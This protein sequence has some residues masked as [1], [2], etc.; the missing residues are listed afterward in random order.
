MPTQ[1]GAPPPGQK[2][3]KSKSGPPDAQ[4]NS[5]TRGPASRPISKAVSSRTLSE[6][7]AGC[8][9][10]ICEQ[11]LNQEKRSSR[12]PDD[13]LTLMMR[14][15]LLE[16]GYDLIGLIGKGGMGTVYKAQYVGTKNVFGV[17]AG[18][19]VAIKL[20]AYDLL[21]DPDSKTRFFREA[22]LIQ[23]ITHPNVVKIFEAGERNNIPYFVM[24]YLEGMD[25]ATIIYQKWLEQKTLGI[26]RA[27]YIVR[28]VGSALDLAHS[29]GIVHRDIKPENIFIVREEDKERVKL[30]D[31]GIAKILSM[32]VKQGL[33]REGHMLGT[34][35]YMAPEM[36]CNSNGGFDHRSDIYSLGIVLYEMLTGNVPFEANNDFATISLHLMKQPEPLR[37]RRPDLGIPER[38]E[39]LVMRS[40]AK[41]PDE[42]FCDISE[43]IEE[44]DAC[45]LEADEPPS[46]RSI[47]PELR[48]TEEKLPTKKKRWGL[49]SVIAAALVVA[50]GGL[51]IGQEQPPKALPKKAAQETD[52]GI[53]RARIE[54]NVPGVKVM[55][56]EKL[57]GG[58][59]VTRELGTTPFE[60]MLR[61]EHLIYFEADGQRIYKR[62]TQKNKNIHCTMPE[63]Q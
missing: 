21:G 56:E 9:P 44:I 43:M 10:T 16:M 33:T 58:T 22:L 35:V 2:D 39:R 38:V 20:L 53:Y 40:L 41:N 28:E 61:G 32:N 50:A 60:V 12:I 3:L 46:F 26:S 14:E 13:P 62:L 1:K 52:N 24:E 6:G 42:R 34:P 8:K 54:T 23:T 15:G 63:G 45:N 37:E 51:C 59:V 17:P 29:K 36:N 7:P 27:L 5:K 49:R 48:S 18:G 47:V 19:K 57:A 25:L 4:N 55:I 30:I 11:V 31:L